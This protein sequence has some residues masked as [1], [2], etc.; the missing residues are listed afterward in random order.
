MFKT[1]KIN[2][3]S[4]M[5]IKEKFHITGTGKS[6]DPII[7]NSLFSTYNAIKFKNISSYISV[8][9]IIAHEIRIIKSRNINVDN[10]KI[11]RLDIVACH[12]ITVKNSSIFHGYL[13]YNRENLFK[14][15]I[16]HQDYAALTFSEKGSK[17]GD[18][19]MK[20]IQIGMPIALFFPVLIIVI[21]FYL[22]SVIIGLLSMLI[23]SLLLI[24][25]IDIEIKKKLVKDFGP[26]QFENNGYDTLDDLHP[27]FLKPK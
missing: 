7:I 6:K 12:K 23:F 15:N 22:I 21:S 2:E 24:P 1:L 26:N 16:F 5:N 13:K 19:N 8:K 20:K 11:F 4:L 9:D 10:C 27:L 17:S 25:V 14:D 18:L 3:R